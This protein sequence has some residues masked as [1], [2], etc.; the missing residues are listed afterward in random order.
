[1]PGKMA[2]LSYLQVTSAEEI[3]QTK[4]FLQWLKQQELMVSIKSLNLNKLDNYKL[5]SVFFKIYDSC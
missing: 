5:L 4:I 3:H 1:M 2:D